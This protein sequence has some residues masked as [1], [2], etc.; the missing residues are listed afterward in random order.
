MH[1]PDGFISGPLN[2]AAGAAAAG[3]VGVSAWRVS[4]EVEKR[5]RAVPLLATTGAFVFA[6]QMLNFPVA[7]GTSGHFMGGAV[8]AALLGPWSA[9]LVMALVLVIQCFMFHDGGATALGTNIFN[10]GIVAGFGAYL[11]MRGMRMVLP[12]GRLSFL[13]SAF[14][15]AWVSIV[16]AAS[17]CALELALSGTSPLAI[18]LPAM[19]GTH[20]LIGIGEALITVAVLSAVIASRPDILPAWAGFNGEKASDRGRKG[21]WAVALIGLAVALALGIFVSPFASSSP[22]GLEKVAED[23]GFLDAAEEGEPLVSAPL[24]DY[25]VPGIE[26]EGPSTGMAGFLGTVAVFV[27][28]YV[29][30][31]LATLR[32]RTGEA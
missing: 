15:A 24:P 22:D 10:M 28:G 5:P 14:V 32:R 19:A 9:C 31:R 23:H 20:A 13:A 6:A 7:A 12:G 30:I 1:I 18:V 3:A 27:A 11:L 16:L 29:A 17:A 8:I 21:A 25:A 26:A 4:R 2:L